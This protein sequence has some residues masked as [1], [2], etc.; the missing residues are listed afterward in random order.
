MCTNFIIKPSEPL[1]FLHS[2]TRLLSCENGCYIRLF[3]PYRATLLLID[4]FLEILCWGFAKSPEK[5]HVFKIWDK[6]IRHFG[7]RRKRFM[8]AYFT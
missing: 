7:R 8:T 5:I 1:I 4:D 3:C 2:L 6:S